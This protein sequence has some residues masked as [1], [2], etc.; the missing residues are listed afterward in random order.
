MLC[1]TEYLYRYEKSAGRTD[2]F[3]RKQIDPASDLTCVV[4]VFF[5]GTYV[6]YEPIQMW[7]CTYYA[8]FIC[9]KDLPQ[10]KVIYY[11]STRLLDQFL[12]VRRVGYWITYHQYERDCLTP[13]TSCDWQ[14]NW[15]LD[16]WEID[17]PPTESKSMSSSSV[18]GSLHK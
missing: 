15:K 16:K 12:S 8:V 2:Y 4:H 11:T 13:N 6:L 3:G 17:L 9:K 14:K 1:I 7:C 10:A 5:L 18:R